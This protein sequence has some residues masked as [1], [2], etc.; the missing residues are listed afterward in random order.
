M[1]QL[2]IG[3]ISSQSVIYMVTWYKFPRAVGGSSGI[4]KEFQ[5]RSC[6]NVLFVFIT[7]ILHSQKIWALNLAEKE[8]AKALHHGSQIR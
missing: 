5:L 1:S 7:Y 4:K 8:A 3:E 6:I 2:K